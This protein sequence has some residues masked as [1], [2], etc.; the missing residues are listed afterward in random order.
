MGLAVW[1]WAP[2]VEAPSETLYDGLDR[3][4]AFIE[5][6]GADGLRPRAELEYGPDG[7]LAASRS[8]RQAAGAAAG[9]TRFTCDVLGRCTAVRDAAGG[10]AYAF[11]DADGALRE[12]VGADGSI[13][14][15][16]YDAAGRI[17]TLERL[18][19]AGPPT[20]L[21]R[22]YDP[23][24]HLE[25]EGISCG[26]DSRLTRHAVDARGN[27]VRTVLP[28]A[29]E[30]HPVLLACH[31]ANDRVTLLQRRLVHPG[32]D[33][34]ADAGAF[35]SGLAFGY[36]ARGRLVSRVRL[37]TDPGAACAPGATH[38][39][40]ADV[41][42]R[43]ADG[44]PV[45]LV[46]ALGTPAEAVTD[47]VLD[48][49]GRVRQALGPETPAGRDRLEADWT[50]DGLLEELRVDDPR[51]AA[52]PGKALRAAADPAPPLLPALRVAYDARRLPVSARDA[53]GN[54]TRSEYDLDGNLVAR[55]DPAGIP[56]SF[57][58]D[59]LGRLV[60]TRVAGVLRARYLHDAA[61]RLAAV[62]DPDGRRTD[63]AWDDHGRLTSVLGPAA[64]GTR[65]LTSWAYDALGRPA[66]RTAPSGRVTA[67]T[68][69][70]ADRVVRET[71]TD[72]AATVADVATAYDALGLPASVDDGAVR[73][74]YAWTGPA[75]APQPPGR[76][77]RADW[78]VRGIPVG[79]VSAAY[80]AR[81]RRTA[82]TGP[83]GEVT[84][85]VYDAAD[86]VAKILRRA[87]GETADRRFAEMLWRPGGLPKETRLG[88]GAVKTY[89]WDAAGRLA[90]LDLAA[91]S[92]RLLSSIGYAYD[93]RG[94]RTRASLRHL[95]A[96]I[97]YGYDALS[98]LVSERCEAAGA[99]PEPWENVF[100]DLPPGNEG[101]PAAPVTAVP[102]PPAAGLPAW[103]AAYAYDG[104]GNR[105]LKDDSR[106]GRFAYDYDA[107]GRLALE[108]VGG[109]SV[110][111]PSASVLPPLPLYGYTY[112]PDGN[113]V[114][115]WG[116]DASGARDPAKPVLRFGY[117]AAGRLATFRA[118]PDGRAGTAPDVAWTYAAAPG[119]QR[120]L[121][122]DDATGAGE[123]YLCDGTD[124]VADFDVSPSGAWER[125][126][127]YVQGPGVDSKI[128]AVDPVNEAAGLFFDVD[129]LGTVLQV[130]GMP[131]APGEDPP[132]A[133]PSARTRLPRPIRP[134]ATA[135]P[136]AS[137]TP[138]AASS[139]SAP[140]TTGPASGGSF[141]GIRSG[142]ISVKRMPTRM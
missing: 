46:A 130:T 50:P 5:P 83:A 11:Y 71:V 124:V 138:K 117:D 74:Q 37:T 7:L 113:L 97:D 109:H 35:V 105:T 14:R 81:G 112:D 25:A 114:E 68:Y 93:A 66:S 72:G 87:P 99:G 23:D 120:I 4:V 128:A 131:A 139:T 45:R 122:R 133:S 95:G 101:D 121:R 40:V 10:T 70:A 135:S 91:P 27:R 78:T 84:T 60:E 18:D 36:D 137:T 26:A 69:D 51:D 38:A 136:S 106:L 49:A 64:G 1:R 82:V 75:D 34:A 47:L 54:E 15:C 59:D 129:A 96:T 6:A 92:G 16:L 126:R 132:G 67:W 62:T 98:R 22:A 21:T 2:G 90:A 119:G 9:E 39:G 94:N 48:G 31:D 104:A 86:R 42:T 57:A 79:S 65:P 76:L 19:R 115:R 125:K 41:V 102:A 118:F 111:D 73:V 89:A 29:P 141:R 127:G 107:A 116:A 8:P 88:N 30:G 44:L 63:L 108:S 56:A 24:G 80:D 140:A 58:Y 85:F 43:D 3:P 134:P 33:P 123:G 61:G 13:V 32:G 52:P 110:A 53:L 28:P 100:S 77:K 17:Q 142:T 12:S 55:H 20:V 103:Q